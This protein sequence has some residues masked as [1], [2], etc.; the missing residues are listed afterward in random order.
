MGKNK[1]YLVQ[2]EGYGLEDDTWEP[3][4][5]LAHAK[6]AI[7]S[8]LAQGRAT[9]RGEYHV[10]ASI[11]K[12]IREGRIQEEDTE[13]QRKINEESNP[14]RCASVKE[15]TR[16]KEQDEPAHNQRNE[17][18]TDDSLTNESKE[19]DSSANESSINANR[20]TDQGK[21]NQR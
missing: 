16:V 14:N 20:S 3:A 8:F 5:N 2:W 15:V 9:K 21:I 4:I 7:Q 18:T 19:D 11:T 12:E 10:M 13:A 17:L 1:E 6:G